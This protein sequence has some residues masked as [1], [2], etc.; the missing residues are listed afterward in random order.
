MGL[1]NILIPPHVENYY[2]KKLEFT[3]KRI[4]SVIFI[5]SLFEG[6]VPLHRSPPLHWSQQFLLLR[7]TFPRTHA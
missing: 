4:F 5:S 7:I 3:R 6:E 1:T 2:N